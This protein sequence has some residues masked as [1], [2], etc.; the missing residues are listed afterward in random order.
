[1][2]SGLVGFDSPGE[3]TVALV[4]VQAVGGLLNTS[5]ITVTLVLSRLWEGC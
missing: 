1:M 4:I 2:F 5:V 3:M